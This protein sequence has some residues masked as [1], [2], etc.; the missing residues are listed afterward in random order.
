MK[1]LGGIEKSFDCKG[2]TDIMAVLTKEVGNGCTLPNDLDI[3]TPCDYRLF[4]PAIVRL[5]DALIG[6]GAKVT[7]LKGA[8]RRGDGNLSQCIELL[9]G[10]G[11]KDLSFTKDDDSFQI[12]HFEEKDDALR[13]LVAIAGSRFVNGVGY[14][15]K[16]RVLAA[17]YSVRTE[18]NR[19]A[20]SYSVCAFKGL[21]AFVSV[22]FLSV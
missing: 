18:Y 20:L 17:L 3:V 4:H 19:R 2:T 5:I 10:K 1:V 8:D 12:L 9:E 6:R 11:R 7:T 14:N 15:L 16:N 21:Y 13:Y 22:C